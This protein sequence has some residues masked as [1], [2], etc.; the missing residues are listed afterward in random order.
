VIAL[1]LN[2]DVSA[3]NNV[4]E[5][6]P[7]CVRTASSINSA[8]IVGVF[9]SVTNKEKLGTIK[10]AVAVPCVNSAPSSKTLTTPTLTDSAAKSIV[11][12][13]FNS[14]LNVFEVKTF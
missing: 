12:S 5:N 11:S 3:D 10:L 7:D 9:C 6:P 14:N 8:G 1:N 4:P 2:T 13:G